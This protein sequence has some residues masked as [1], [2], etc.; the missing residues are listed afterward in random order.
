[1]RTKGHTHN[2]GT[3]IGYD[4][5]KNRDYFD[6]VYNNA[7][8]LFAD[9]CLKYCLSPSKDIVCHSEVYKL[10]YGSNHADVMHWFPK[11]GKSMDTFREDL[12]NKMS[13]PAKTITKESPKED[14]K[15]L[16]DKLNS[17][18]I[19]ESNIPLTVNGTYDNKTRI[20]VLIYWEKLGWNK[21]G[22]ADG[23]RA[24]KNTIKAL[25]QN[26]RD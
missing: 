7:V 5:I 17:V 2:G 16:Q 6:K 4:V 18:L 22:S 26:L 21:D 23:W 20:A 12:K 1:M 14:I 13:M 25:V 8:E 9:L 24:G 3:M 19:G 15:W 11:H 10:G